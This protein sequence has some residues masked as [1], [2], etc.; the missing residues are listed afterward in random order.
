MIQIGGR[1][2][3]DG[4][5]IPRKIEWTCHTLIRHPFYLSLSR[6]DPRSR[7]KK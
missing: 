7:Y 6:R 3:R 1:T 4:F 2:G 5:H